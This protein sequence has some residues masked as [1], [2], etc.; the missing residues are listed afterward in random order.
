MHSMVK[1][2]KKRGRPPVGDKPMTQ[3]A[4]RFPDDLLDGIDEI[5]ASRYGQADR[6]AIIRELVAQGLADRK[7]AKR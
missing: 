4:V 7:R 5:V 3:L 2:P 1:Q 6:T